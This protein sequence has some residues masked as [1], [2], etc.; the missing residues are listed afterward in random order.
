MMRRLHT[1]RATF[2]AVVSRPFPESTMQ[3]ERRA[4]LNLLWSGGQ[5]DLLGEQQLLPVDIEQPNF[6]SPDCPL[7]GDVTPSKM[8]VDDNARVFIC[9]ANPTHKALMCQ[10][11]RK[12]L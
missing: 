7:C 1:P 11:T 8:T 5:E 2:M 3:N 4:I 12:P 10:K 6:P 9:E